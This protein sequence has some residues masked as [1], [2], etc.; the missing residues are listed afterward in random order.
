[1]SPD[2]SAFERDKN[3]FLFSGIAFDGPLEELN[4]VYRQRSQT[5]RTLA[6]EANAE[7]CERAYEFV[8]ER[9]REAL[10]AGAAAPETIARKSGAPESGAVTCAPGQTQSPEAESESDAMMGRTERSSTSSSIESSSIDASVESSIEPK[11][12]DGSDSGIVSHP[13]DATREGD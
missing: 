7:L 6:E 9:L 3:Q 8:R 13:T 12:D 11:S 10:A 2:E 5:Y 4:A 1:M